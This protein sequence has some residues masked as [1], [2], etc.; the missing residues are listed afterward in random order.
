MSNE[1][2]DPVMPFPK[3][4]SKKQ[5][6]ESTFKNS[7]HD[8]L[9]K[10][11]SQIH[12]LLNQFLTGTG[13][14]DLTKIGDAVNEQVKD[15]PQINELGKFFGS[16]LN[17]SQQKF[18]ATEKNQDINALIDTLGKACGQQIKKALE[19]VQQRQEKT[20]E[21]NQQPPPHDKKEEPIKQ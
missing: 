20:T 9:G 17:L 13:E 5:E 12:S 2:N 4:T 7:I 19:E 8:V 15:E 18:Q 10:D 16:F 14:P 6:Y 11:G 1:D 3:N 21:T